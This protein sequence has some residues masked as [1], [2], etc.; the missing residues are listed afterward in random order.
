MQI[1]DGKA[2]ALLLEEKIKQYL[3]QNP[4]LAGPGAK[5]LG[6]IQIGENP[7]SKT[8]VNLKKKF[9]SSLNI[10][11]ETL[12]LEESLSDREIISQARDFFGRQDISGGLVQLPL[13]RASLEP[14]LGVI[15]VGKDIDLLSPES[16]RKFYAGEFNRLSPTVR[17]FDYFLEQ[18]ELDQGHLSVGIIGYGELV[19]KPIAH[20]ST[21]SGMDTKI[22]GW[23]ENGNRLDY[24]LLVLSAGV[25]NLVDPENISAGTSVIDFGYSK[26]GDKTVG[27]LDMSKNMDHLGYISPSIGGMGPLVI[28]FLVMNFL[29]I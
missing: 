3:T 17:A 19:G 13:P 9:C 11:V 7:A 18:T 21:V 14:V 26:L 25:P 29:G 12:L 8:Y 23:Y 6:I 15:P 10:P 24:Q 20:F 1:F 16:K 5:K 4:H 28:R 2:H 27:D 22:V